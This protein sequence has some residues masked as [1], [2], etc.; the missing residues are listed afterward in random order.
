MEKNAAGK[1]TGSKGMKASQHYNDK[2]GHEIVKAWRCAKLKECVESTNSPP[3]AK[4]KAKAKAAVKAS[5]QAKAEAK[6][7]QAKKRSIE[8]ATSMPYWRHCAADD[9]EAASSSALSAAAR[10]QRG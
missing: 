1:A 5:V 4:A 6:A 9:N 7:M 8:V 10:K 3:Q 2:F